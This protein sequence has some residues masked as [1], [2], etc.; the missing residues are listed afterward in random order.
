M[1]WTNDRVEMLRGLWLHGRTAS[2]IAAQL[3]GVTR[4]AVIGKAHRMGLSGRPSPIRQPMASQPTAS[5]PMP[6]APLPP[7]PIAVGGGGRTCM[8]PVGDPKQPDFHFCG[9]AVEVGR[10]Y[11]ATHCALAYH[12]KTEV[13]A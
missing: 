2:Q 10:P 11:C 8:W 6:S 7:R 9:A 13:A 3:G 5:R 4:N 12:R 1:E